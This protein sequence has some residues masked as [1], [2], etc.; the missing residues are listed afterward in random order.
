MT[1][2]SRAPT[3]ALPSRLPTD[4]TQSNTKETQ[5]LRQYMLHPVRAGPGFRRQVVLTLPHC[6][7]GRHPSPHHPEHNSRL[8]RGR[9]GQSH[10]ARSVRSRHERPPSQIS[11]A[12]IFS[13]IIVM[14]LAHKHFC[15]VS[16]TLEQ[17]RGQQWLSRF[18]ST[19]YAQSMHFFY[20]YMFLSYPLFLYFFNCVVQDRR[21]SVYPIVNTI[22]PTHRANMQN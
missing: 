6:T 12:L 18:L 14:S 5:T 19:V 22:G 1:T 17:D 3:T 16:N 11:V 8:V 13:C 20:F 9:K 10:E 4:A 15:F 7:S 21:T 2:Y